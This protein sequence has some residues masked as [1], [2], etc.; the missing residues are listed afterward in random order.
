MRGAL[1]LFDA[2]PRFLDNAVGRMWCPNG[3]LAVAFP[4][5]ATESNRHVARSRMDAGLLLV[6]HPPK[7]STAYT[8]A[9]WPA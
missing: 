4:K 3:S 6:F 8:G 1:L 5:K 9:T 7:R 2:L